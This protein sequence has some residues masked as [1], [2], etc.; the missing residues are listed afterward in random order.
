MKCGWVAFD[1]GARKHAFAAQVDGGREENGELENTPEAIMR[2]LAGQRGRCDRLR[3]V[4]EATG[5][6]YLDL[7]LQAVQAGAEVMVINPKA[8]HHFARA[9]GQRSKTDALDA[10]MLLTY[11]QRMDF[12]PWQP[13]ARAVLELRQWGRHLA[14]LVEQ[15][16]R[17]KNQLH[18]LR[19]TTCSPAAVLEDMEQAL[20]ALEQRIDRL[21]AQ[22]QRRVRAEATIAA[23]FDALD[24]MIGVG[25]TS[26]LSLLVELLVL[27]PDMNSRACVCHA[28]LDVRI[29][30]SGTSVELAPRLSKHGNKYL[31]R[32]LY[33]PAMT[34]VVHDPHARAFRDRL[35]A[36][37][38]KKMQALAAVM[39]KLLTAAWALVRK[40]ATYDGAKLFAAVEA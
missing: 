15:R 14:R 33:M 38:K 24:S 3:V 9:L 2:F 26:A 5:I 23:G 4:M 13:P 7:A 18:A 19:S 39:R 28:G 17:Q 6:Y 25:P 36:R 11:L 1:V 27:P 32:A 31:R 21:T 37:G 8:A 29:H 40:P 22:A 16:V 34:A 30:R 12:V 20:Q 35:I 10:R